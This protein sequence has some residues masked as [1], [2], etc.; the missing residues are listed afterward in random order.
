MYVVGVNAI[1]HDA[2]AC[3]ALD[4]TVICAAEEE[5]FS[6]SKHAVGQRPHRALSWCLQKAGITL[7][8]VSL[9]ATP[10]LLQSEA[11]RSVGRYT[12]GLPA[13]RSP[14]GFT[15]ELD[16]DRDYPPYLAPLFDRFQSE[17]RR[18][19][20]LVRVSHHLAHAASAYR[21]SGWNDA[22]VLVVDGEG[23][24]VSTT[25]ARGRRGVLEAQLQLPPSHSLG[26]LYSALAKYLG[27][28]DFGEGKAMGLATF[29][30]ADPLDAFRLDDEGYSVPKWFPTSFEGN[31]A[32]AVKTAWV[33]YL[34]RTFGA[35]GVI[36]PD[37]HSA[38]AGT[39]AAAAVQSELERVLV[40]IARCATK[41]A[42][43]GRLAVAGGVG[44]NCSANGVLRTL[45]EIEDLY[46]QP[47]AGDAGAA[48]GAALE[49]GA[50]LLGWRPSR[51]GHMYLG[52][53][54]SDT[55]VDFV[56]REIGVDWTEINDPAAVA[57]ELIAEGAIIGWFSGAAEFGPRALGHRSILA[58][59][60]SPEVRDRVNRIKHR[61]LWRPLAPSV[62]EDRTPLLFGANVQLPFM[63]ER[64][65][66]TSDFLDRIPGVV[67]VDSS[68]RPHTV[69]RGIEPTYGRLLDHFEART[70]LP[71]VINTSFNDEREPMVLSPRDAIATFFSTGLS[72]LV[73]NGA[74]LRKSR[75]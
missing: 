62:L 20:P 37:A 53:E 12:T 8:D 15:I 39:V 33:N 66:A 52:P 56:L 64:T 40:S 60:A 26:H 70:G 47:A 48:I 65:I 7:A 63:V 74:L 36:D 34:H 29:G 19:P 57:A 42:G 25:I 27:F 73:F 31:G 50:R 41:Y 6:R 45:P 43:T 46:L 67:H 59:P 17:S 21:C 2:S 51:L 71:C 1:G 16:S 30:R 22:A 72:A 13:T 68:M 3:I 24:G 14:Q 4:G 9:V 11:D 23:D 28:A 75:P 38:V 5:R 18:L 54:Y 58:T 35:C 69:D 49:A 55:D 10:W 32:E 61:E 44:F